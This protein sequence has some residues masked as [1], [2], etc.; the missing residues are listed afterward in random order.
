MAARKKKSAKAPAR[1][2]ALAR[3]ARGSRGRAREGASF[4]VPP[5][6]AALPRGY[7]KTLREIKQRIQRQRLRA[8]MAANS[9]MVLLYWD[10]GRMVL[11]RQEREGW[12]ADR[13]SVV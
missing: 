8:V 5:P 13:K 11:E 1:A 7:A 3:G 12:G 6:R 10:I 9:A 2:A 4:P